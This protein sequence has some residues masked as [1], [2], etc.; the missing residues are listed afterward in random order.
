MAKRSPE[1]GPKMSSAV[2]RIW[3]KPRRRAPNIIRPDERK[4][5]PPRV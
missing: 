5:I 2:Q 3:G 4:K 1:I